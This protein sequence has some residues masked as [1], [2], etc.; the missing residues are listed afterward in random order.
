MLSV[1]GKANYVGSKGKHQ[2]VDLGVLHG[3][4][5]TSEDRFLGTILIGLTDV[6]CHAKNSNSTFLFSE[7]AGVV[8]QIWE[9]KDRNDG[10]QHGG[11]TFDPVEPPPSAVPEG[12]F[13]VRQ[14]GGTDEG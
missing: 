4:D 3:H 9:D 8:R 5:Q 11:G 12:T 14:D 7:A 13:H 6:F 10:D 2:D 1:Q